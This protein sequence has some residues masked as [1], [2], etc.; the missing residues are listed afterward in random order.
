MTDLTTNTP[1]RDGLILALAEH[2]H[3]GSLPP[4]YYYDELW[5]AGFL[6]SVHWHEA[7]V[8]D[9]DM[10]GRGHSWKISARGWRYLIHWGFALPNGFDEV[11][12]H[13]REGA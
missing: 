7:D 6:Y 11:E 13:L 10:E 3:V 2:L 5:D 9:P 12:T 8:P 1:I 4:G